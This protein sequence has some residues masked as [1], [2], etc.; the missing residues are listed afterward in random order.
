MRIKRYPEIKGFIETSFLDWRGFLSS[1]IF[2]GGCNFRCPFCH[3]RDLVLN[4]DSLETVPLSWV[5]KRFIKFKSWVSRVVVSGGEP[6][7][8]EGLFHL[9]AKLKG[10]GLFVK[11]DTNGSSPKV[12]EEL[13]D[14]GLVDYVAMDVKGPL[15]RYS[16]WCGVSVDGKLIKR[17][18]DVVMSSGIDYEFRMTYV[19]GF[20]D[21][22]DVLEVAR[23][24][25]GAKR[26]I[27]QE[28]RPKDTIDPSFMKLSSCSE[29]EMEDLRKR[30]SD[31]L[32]S[33]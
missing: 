28:F 26:F 22:N 23:A 21:E 31:I 15:T 25:S 24:L 30:V 32:R 7:I 3:N 14:E 12:L 27:L 20:H 16:K 4:P 11:L 18:I 13:I 6:T 29:E 17:S 1:V 8:H 19:P 5:E 2:L 10:I 33:S 9:L